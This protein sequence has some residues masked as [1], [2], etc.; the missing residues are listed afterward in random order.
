MTLV[1]PIR[2][3]RKTPLLYNGVIMG[4]SHVRLEE[5]KE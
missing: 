1:T 5:V 3:A 2:A 4:R